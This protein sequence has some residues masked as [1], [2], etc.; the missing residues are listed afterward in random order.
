MNVGDK[1]RDT[2]NYYFDFYDLDGNRL[3]VCCYY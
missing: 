2:E 3:Q 1:H